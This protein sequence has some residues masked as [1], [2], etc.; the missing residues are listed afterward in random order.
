[1]AGLMGPVVEAGRAIGVLQAPNRSVWG[2]VVPADET[3]AVENA[4]TASIGE[5]GDPLARFDRRWC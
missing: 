4:G 2:G 3:A 1:M 5:G